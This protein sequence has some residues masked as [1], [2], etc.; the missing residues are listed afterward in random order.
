[1]R[2]HTN[3]CAADVSCV[4]CVLQLFQLP[5]M[6]GLGVTCGSRLDGIR[7]YPGVCGVIEKG[8]IK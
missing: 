3:V 6:Q 2:C 1:M 4:A 5:V 7:P 8:D